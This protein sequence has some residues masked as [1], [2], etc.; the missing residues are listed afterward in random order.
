MQ[1]RSSPGR[2]KRSDVDKRELIRSAAYDLFS[3]HGFEKTT[4][5]LV[6][7]HAEVDPKLVM[8]YFGSKQKLFI[9]TVKAPEEAQLA[10]KL[11]KM[12]PKALWGKN[13][14]HAI[15]LAQ[16]S[17][18]MK[19]LIGVIRAA[20]S[21]PEAAEMFREFYIENLM[22]PMVENLNV[23]HKE[24][25][26]VMISSLMAGYAFNL[27]ITKIFDSPGVSE[28]LTKKLFAEMIQTILTSK[29]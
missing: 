8:H 11:L 27:E 9:S 14:A 1:V 5:R 28:K 21:E 16:K 15:W 23:D 18:S 6:A 4:I 24:T 10:L 20:A 3:E 12:S 25:R 29:L 26:A 2:P 7:Q 17:G 19:T 22:M 13:I